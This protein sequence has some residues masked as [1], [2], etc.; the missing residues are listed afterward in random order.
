M[1]DMVDE[2]LPGDDAEIDAALDAALD[3]EADIAP[4]WTGVVETRTAF[5]KPTAFGAPSSDWQSKQRAVRLQTNRAV[6]LQTNE[7][8]CDVPL[9]NPTP[10]VL[11][12]A[13]VKAVTPA[14]A[15]TAFAVPDAA[16]VA[17][18][19][20]AQVVVAP[21][22]PSRR[23]LQHL[24]AQT[25]AVELRPV[26]E[27][28][29]AP[30]PDANAA[31]VA[32]WKAKHS[33]TASTSVATPVV[34]EPISTST[35]IE[36]KLHVLWIGTH[37]P[38]MLLI[39]SWFNKHPAW[40]VVF[41]RDHTKGWQNQDVI[42]RLAK[43]E[44]NGAADVMR[45]EILAK[46]G[47]IAVDADSMCL[48]ALD[49]G[50]EDFLANDK[51][52]AF[53][54]NEAVRPGIIACGVMGTPPGSAFFAECVRRVAGVDTSLPAWK[55]VGPQLITDVAR[56]LPN[57]IRVYPAKWVHPMH[58][59]GTAAPGASECKP[60]CD[61]KWGSTKGYQSTRPFPCSCALCRQG[62]CLMP[63]WG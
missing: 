7:Q 34:V 53:Y 12:E 17:A 16:Q 55:T 1:V 50:P 9:P 57:D 48:R 37:D 35:A 23:G 60:Y 62:N 44:W 15:P 27:P 41:W 14:V 20:V 39:D 8:R 30:S 11:A 21:T 25:P 22:R 18:P 49:E 2:N 52:F 36:R 58:F 42:D 10:T 29:V 4:A 51:A 45:L 38:P 24:G 46:E 13:V 6:W 32:Q 5:A 28:P 63:S 19:Q 3:R 40:K 33:A 26:V 61:Q 56:S 47:G 59:N 31:W 43:R 54:E